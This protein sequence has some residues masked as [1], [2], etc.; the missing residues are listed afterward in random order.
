MEKLIIIGAGKFGREVYTW[1]THLNKF[2]IKGFLDNRPNILE[3]FNYDTPILGSAE[4]YIPEEEDIFICAI[5]Y[6]RIK[7]ELCTAIENKG[8]KFINIIHPSAVLGSNIKMGVGNIICPN[9]VI[10]SDIE[11]GNHNTINVLSSIAHD[12]KIGNYCQINILINVTG[13]VILEDLVLLN[14]SCVIAPGILIGED[15]IV[16]AGSIVLKHIPKGVVVFGN[17][18][19]EFRKNI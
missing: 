12:T 17:P 7:K 10:S 4:D 16:G 3:G 18:A 2:I 11:I 13:N 1:I 8:G 5:G 19:K 6:P 15:S 9:A 14:S